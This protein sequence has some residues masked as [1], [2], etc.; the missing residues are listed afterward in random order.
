MNATKR[1]SNSEIFFHHENY[2]NRRR[3]ANFL[4]MLIMMM[5]D[6]IFLFLSNDLILICDFMFIYLNLKKKVKGI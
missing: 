2:N 1:K 4:M 5:N 6:E 3:E